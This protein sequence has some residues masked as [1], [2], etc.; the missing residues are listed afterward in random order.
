MLTLLYYV[1]PFLSIY[2][3]ISLEG[4][5]DRRD[6]LREEL[7]KKQ[8]E[9]EDIDGIQRLLVSFHRSLS[10]LYV[11]LSIHAYTLHIPYDGASSSP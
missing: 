5:G 7:A 8:I 10:H 11:V 1:V 6:R 9:G 4:P 2:G 3:Y